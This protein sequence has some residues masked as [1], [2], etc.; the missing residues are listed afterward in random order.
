MVSSTGPVAERPALD[1]KQR[2]AS[3]GRGRKKLPGR[4]MQR[5]TND[6]IIVDLHPG[7]R[8][9]VPFA[10]IAIHFMLANPVHGGRIRHHALIR[11]GQHQMIIDAETWDKAQLDF[12]VGKAR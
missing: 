7:N 9:D 11:E 8:G 6:A 12:K 5:R 1:H 10:R 3:I 2:C 4:R